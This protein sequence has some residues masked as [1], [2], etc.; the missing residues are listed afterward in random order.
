MTAGAISDNQQAP[1]C[2]GAAA[3]QQPLP[4]I[5]R[6][7]RRVLDRRAVQHPQQTAYDWQGAT[8]K[9]VAKCAPGGVAGAALCAAG[10]DAGEASDSWQICHPWLWRL[11]E[12]A[13]CRR[14]LQNGVLF[15][16]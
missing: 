15:L 10:G 9:L 14:C 12:A 2:A 8:A 4:R 3:V 11:H 16:H 5:Q 6:Q 13:A 7:P 1:G